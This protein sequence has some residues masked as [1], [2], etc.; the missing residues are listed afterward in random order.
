MKRHCWAHI[1]ALS[2]LVWVCN[3]YANQ[4]EFP[5]PMLFAGQPIADI[6]ALSD[7][8]SISSVSS[9]DLIEALNGYLNET[10]YEKL[11]SEGDG[12][13]T[14]AKLKDI[15][16]NLNFDPA[17]LVIEL[18]IDSNA[19]TEFLLSFSSEYTPAVY[20]KPAYV[21]WHNNFNITAEN[22]TTENI[23]NDSQ[24]Y[25][26]EWLL[27]GN[28]GGVRGLNFDASFFYS[29]GSEQENDI[30][31]GEARVFFDNPDSP[32]RATFGDITPLTAGH[33][34][35]VPL[36]GIALERLYDELQPTRNIQ[37][38]GTQPFV[39][40]ESAEVEIYINDVYVSELRLPP[41][42][43]RLDDLPLV[44]GAN[45]I[46]IEIRYQSGETDTVVYS[47]FFNTRLLREGFSDFG[48]YAGLLSFIQ[49]DDF[50]YDS[51][52]EVLSGYY[53][54]GLTDT[55]TLGLNG[56]Y[57]PD[58]QQIGSVFNWGTF[59]GNI[60]WRLSGQTNNNLN[61]QGIISSIDYSHRVWGADSYGLPNLRVSFEYLDRYNSLPWSENEGSSGYRV[62]T[63]YIYNLTN[64]LDLNIDA[65]LDNFD[66][67]EQTWFT[68]AKLAW[69][70]LGVQITTGVEHEEDPNEN[71]SDTRYT[72]NLS[73]DWT[74]TN[75]DYR[76]NASYSN[77]TDLGRL[78][79]Q[80]T[81]DDKAGSYGYR[82][83]SEFEENTQTY[84]AL[85][86]YVGN[87]FRAEAETNYIEVNNGNNIH[88]T[89]LR[90]S[91]AISFFDSNTSWSRAYSG[92]AVMVSVH[93]SLES[94]VLINALAGD[95][96]DAVSTSTLS[97]T[98]PLSS[99]HVESSVYISAPDAPIGYDI[100]EYQHNITP[101]SRTGHLIYIGSADSK[102]VIGTLVDQQGKP[103]GLI[104]GYLLSKELE[105]YPLFT[106][107]SGR[108]VV[109]GISEGSFELW[110]NGRTT[111]LG[112]ISI[113]E[114]TDSLIY[115]P[116]FTAQG[117]TL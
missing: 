14:L 73:W 52:Q 13:I 5:F 2:T 88:T 46:R 72:V 23:S 6:T 69:Q 50:E 64:R 30:Y 112:V 53:E 79:F 101:G 44:A 45:D 56:I 49:D 110:V 17:E 16:I 61:E 29:D 108:F 99:G 19:A 27:S 82:L 60:G 116:A 43:Y 51:D 15:G 74:S 117:E 1:A 93:D 97:N 57:H 111:P 94:D 106:N 7:G 92:P 26:F 36:G 104:Q 25:L 114:S 98:V 31:R 62:V 39:L 40:N 91:T 96:P 11:K 102:T 3:S 8:T 38:G 28:I 21:A 113:P 65:D 48:I 37:N 86:D 34:P 107:T 18:Y 55:I 66:D 75:S 32:W 89:A 78:R 47:Q 41:G 24:T 33:L 59:L 9:T 85:A 54:Y 84:S 105:R 22:I 10:A 67:F 115:L 35:N 58:G 68:S 4:W 90:G 83:T 80:K 77:E 71:L 95:A 76:A 42:R 20:S 12:F 100:G 70:S 81:S 103:I 63:S 87:R 109:E